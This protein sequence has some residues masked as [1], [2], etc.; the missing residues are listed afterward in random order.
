M[1]ASNNK[2]TCNGTTDFYNL[3]L[4]KGVD[5]TYKLT[6]YSTAYNRFRLF[7]ANNSGG[8]TNGATNQNPNLKKALWIRTGTLELTGLTVIPSLTEGSNDGTPNSDFYV[9]VNGAL[10]LN[11]PDV[12]VLTTAD[13][14]R[15]INAAYGVSGGTGSVNGVN[16]AS[17]ASSFSVYGKLQVNDGYFSTRESGG[18]VTWDYASGQLEVNGGF[19]DTKQIRAAGGASGLASY[20]QT[21]GIVSLRGRFQ[22]TPAQYTSSADLA[23]M[24]DATINTNR[25]TGGVDGSK[26][27]FN[28]N[29]TANVYAMTG[30]SVKIYDVCDANGYA[31]DIFSS[32]ANVS[33][34]GGSFE[35][36]PMSGNDNFIIRTS[37]PFGNMVL[38]RQGGSTS[39]LQL[40]A[41][42]PLTV[43]KNIDLTSGVFNA[44]GQNVTIGGDFSITSGATYNSG[45][46][47]TLFNGKS[48][49]LLTISGTVNNG[50]AGL[51]NLTIDKS[52][53]TLTLAGTQTTLTVQGVFDLAKGQFNDGGKTVEMLGNITNSGTHI[54]S[55][56]LLFKGTALQ[57]IGGDGNGI[58]QNVEMNNTNA[59]T[60]PISLLAN[61]TINGVL[62][63]ANDKRLDI[64]SYNLKIGAN[65]AF[66]GTGTNRFVKTS[67]QSGDGGITKT[68]AAV[69]AFTYPVGVDNYTPAT[70]TLNNVPTSYGNVTILPVNAEHPN[71][72][73][74]GRSLTYYWRVKSTGLVLGSATV[75]HAYTY[76][77]ANL[78]TGSGVTEDG[79]VAA[80]Y[81][82]AT[83][84]WTRGT[85]DDVVDASNLIGEPSSGNFMENVAFVDGDYTAG[86]DSPT[87]PFGVPK[88]YYSRR[89]GTWGTLNT[90]SLTSHTA[91]NVPTAAPGQN[92]VVIIGNG[93]TVTLATH[94]TNINSGVQRCASLQ[95]ETGGTLDIG[96]NPGCV[97]SMVR[98]HP[99]GNGLFRLTTSYN[100][101]STFA[102]PG[103]D[104]SEFNTNL[105][106]TEL[107]TVNST[108]GTTYWL[109]NGTSSYGNLV[110]SP[111]GGSNII[112]PNNDVVV[113]GN[114]ITKGQNSESW[115]CPTWNSNYPTAPTSRVAKTITVKG[116]FELQGGALIYYGNNNL[117]Q[118]FVVDGNVVV[119]TGAGIRVYSDASNQSFKIGGSLINN[120]ALGTGNNAYAGC[121][122]S[123]IPIVFYGN[124]NASLTNTS[125]TPTTV[126]GSVTVNKGTSQASTLT[127]NIGGTLTTPADSWL[128]LQNGT[129]E[130]KRTNPNSDFTIATSSPFTIPAAAG[131]Y[132]DY[133]N[134]GNRNVLIANASSN[135]ND[136]YLSGKLTV[137]S[138]NV[139]V[140]PTSSVNYN[141]DIEYSGG[142]D[143]E[144]EVRGGILVVNGQIR[145]NPSSTSGILKYTQ[146]G[147]SMTINGRNAI[148][149]NAKLEVLNNGSVFNMSG[150]TLNFVYGGG[151]NT[152]GDLYL[153]PETSSVTGGEIVFAHNLSNTPQQYLV[154]ATV[155]LYHMTV[156]GRTAATAANATVKLLVSP[157]TLNGNLT[158][159][160]ANSVLD[161]NSQLNI[162][163]TVN[164]DFTNNGVYNHYN[165]LTT[166]SGGVQTIKGTT[167]T[168][169]YDLKISPVTSVSL[170][171]DVN[172][173]RHMEL[174][175]GQLLMGNYTIYLNGDLVNNAT[176]TTGASAGGVV[177]TGGQ[178]VHLLSGTGTFGRLELNDVLGARLLNGI[179]LQRNFKLA[180]GVLDINKYLLTLGQDANIEGNN[181]GTSKMISSDGVYSNIGIRK[182]FP[183]IASTTEFIYPMGLAGKY[184][185]AVLTILQNATVGAI[186]VNTVNEKH[187]ATL[188]PYRVLDYYWEVESNGIS[189]FKGDVNFYYHTGDVKQAAADE[190]NYVAARLIVPGTSWSKATPGATTD[191]VDE[192]ANKISFTFPSGTSNLSGEYTA[193]LDSDVPN[194]VPVYEANVP[195]N[196][197]DKTIWT[198]VGTAPACPDGGPNGFIV[199]IN[200]EVTAD[201]NNCFA[202]RTTINDKLKIVS[203]YVGHNLGLIE[204]SGTLYLE[205]AVIP[206]GRYTSFVDC[207]NNATIEYGGSGTYNIISDLFS[208][209]P[210]LKVTG[211]GNRILPNADLTVC[212]RLVIDGPTLDNSVNNRS[213]TIKGTMERYHTGV[214]K[215]GTGSNATVVFAGTVAQTIGGASGDF[216]G[217]NTFNN[218]QINNI[219][220]VIFAGTQEVSG[221]LLL[222][223]GTIRTSS[224]SLLRITNTSVTCVYPSAGTST[225]YVDGP[226][227]KR[228]NQGDSFTFP[229]GKDGVLGSKL[230]LSA[231][232]TGTIDWQTEYFAP[233]ATYASYE[234][235]LS[236]VNSKEYWTVAATAG[237]QAIIGI[238]W[239]ASSDVTP[240]VT[241][242]GVSDLRVASYNVSTS[243]WG[244]NA[245]SATGDNNSG[246]ISSSGRIAVPAS[247]RVDLT[248]ATVNT[249][250]PK[251]KLTPSGTICG[252]S[253]GIPVTFTSSAPI[254][255]N[256]ILNYKI[257]G[258]AKAPVTISALP[259]VLPAAEVGTY[260]L[261]SFTYDNGNEAGVVDAGVVTVYAIP[262]TAN[263]GSDLALCGA[264]S[265]TLAAN[266]P[267]VGTG[268]WSIVTGTGGTVVQPTVPSSVFNGTNGSAYTLRWTISN[269]TCTS[270]DDVMVTFP[271]LA[272]QPGT[273][274]ASDA[275]VCQGENNVVYTVPL[276]ATV[277][278]YNWNYS[279][280]GVNIVSNG[281]SATLDYTANATS[282][283]LS[284]T[285]TNGCNTSAARQIS[286]T[287]DPSTTVSIL[288]DDSDNAVCYNQAVTFTATPGTGPSVT[289]EFFIDGVSKQSGSSAVY[290]TVGLLDG[291]IV[292]VAATTS[293][294]CKTYSNN[295]GMS[296]I[297][298]P[299]LWS[300]IV[301]S[302]WDNGGNWCDGDVPGGSYN[303]LINDAVNDPV[304]NE[305]SL[306]QVNT[307]AMGTGATLTLNPGTRM[308]V[309][310]NISNPGATLLIRNTVDK[311]TSFLTYGSVSSP[312]TV[313]WNYPNGRYMYVGHSVDGVTYND[314][315][316]PTAN[317]FSLYRYT[318]STWAAIS[319]GIGSTGLT[320]AE[321]VLE[322]YSV[323][324]GEAANVTISHTGTLRQGNYTRI[325]NG[326]NLVANPYNTYIDL[327][328]SGINLGNSLSTV[329]TTSNASGSTVYATYNIS[330]NIGANGGTRY[331]APGQSFWVRNY[332]AGT[333]TMSNTIRTHATGVLKAA[334]STSDV[335][336]L[337]LTN[338]KV[339][340]ESVL[341]FRDS[342]SESYSTVFDSEKRFSTGTEEVSLYTQK[343][344]KSLIINILPE[345]TEGRVVPLWMNVGAQ[346]AGT[347]TVKA[348]NINEFMPDV[349]VYLLDKATGASVSLREN[350]EYT[351]VATAVSAQN[352]F[353]LNFKAV[354][355]TPEV[356]TGVDENSG[357]DH[358]DITAI[359]IGDKTIVK[360]KDS[361][362]VGKVAIEV[363][364]ASGRLYRNILSETD[365][366]ELEAP[367]NTQFYVVK[368][369]YKNV[370]RSFKII[371]IGK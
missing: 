192:S 123:N 10:L 22:R 241:A 135:S 86:D 264:T 362:F 32:A 109:P 129:F 104:F 156:T 364:D 105:G 172:V 211:T 122:F 190:V 154:D 270:S 315:D 126:L 133:S 296:Q 358:I 305:G 168:D 83:Y 193:G 136:L 268:L 309:N 266:T 239:D 195:G 277:L 18:L 308:T 320:G 114:L 293:L 188:S 304:V 61:M 155:P 150:G 108:A 53:G 306:V 5:Q 370:M 98:N 125:G 325:I 3:V 369:T 84:S 285:A 218:L 162:P 49:Q 359:G 286:I 58:F 339:S 355:K 343:E 164:G 180:S 283:T 349:D 85:V 191:N 171:R 151:G 100:S 201:A 323:K 144:I 287:V 215:A 97:F 138:G 36:Y 337:V 124:N 134:S 260:Q 179:T 319:S 256:Y 92:D 259:Y 332:S 42:Y 60:A 228:I 257:N 251:A 183:I 207:D 140:G 330:S 67:G 45:A 291:Q 368:V 112:F 1:G 35:F 205:S 178:S 94:N 116:N 281:H 177:L 307:I 252:T 253:S 132:V 331:V 244:H 224:S 346:A 176:Y 290:T 327:E 26:G 55:G 64:A 238:G 342:G 366:T 141:N 146:S 279:G 56:K 240:L 8:D 68:F 203:P 282:G 44:S 4:D 348:T 352:R 88:V 170:I 344:S 361:A 298:T 80:R 313:E 149:T 209:V 354:E 182:Y 48:A 219:S 350:P 231:T 297:T 29:A 360:V 74:K 131:L 77:N 128:T 338:T 2:L 317:I 165:N 87:N 120:A 65:A 221:N 235:P 186:R 265:A 137:V 14:Y 15:E 301:D 106:T 70:I 46:N 213:L 161:A 328:N 262:T 73:T 130:Y 71:T 153:R 95:I 310:G 52:S 333:L 51:N 367:A 28:I 113:Y 33:V 292:N 272:Q 159:S 57:T 242:N 157:L 30:G 340:D 62:T 294:G 50:N 324:F 76:A 210:N 181:F 229:V 233:N 147:G 345:E 9:P 40:G 248:S 202:Y 173:L 227:V 31:V 63:F 143:S 311:P 299:G 96:Y 326:W 295:I 119:N 34:S 335:L 12:I 217:N 111:L 25:L 365:R 39:A 37:A 11:G 16:K 117:A 103:G 17:Y 23:A 7:G 276:D 234:A 255:F 118:N 101:Q 54:G 334:S 216:T 258:V 280:T 351:F 166:F 20:L 245:S 284:V 263:A 336:R 160:N 115:F 69:G 269:G 90:W 314:Y 223:S 275:E 289:Y 184:T 82:H 127:C 107:Y 274:T 246:T 329:W 78:V 321:N 278:T 66:A 220:G 214:F 43:L 167:A 300:G 13:D 75:T 59:A 47:T 38:N 79:Y 363:I 89:S 247:G 174:A 41:S 72:T 189:G 267:S 271:L 273:F 6:V 356:V 357:T 158:L 236:Y 225:S 142:G 250:K 99:N 316:V 175:S 222:T 204:G 24:T 21:G 243:K 208:S 163:L 353:E 199:V 93:H 169:F 254:G 81:N 102:F 312:V 27:T 226:M 198:P 206:A 197:T 194:E 19:V 318:G 91:D 148:T 237:S 347:L 187:P 145:R 303:V 110:I 121:D 212:K 196:W 322:G 371:N 139:Y 200:A 152:Y 302:D 249:V 230:K 288:S 185:P 232:Q 341:A 261:T